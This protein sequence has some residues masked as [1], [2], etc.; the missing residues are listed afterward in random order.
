[1][2]LQED[3]LTRLARDAASSVDSGYYNVSY[4]AGRARCNLV[5]AFRKQQRSLMCEIKFASPSTGK[6]SEIKEISMVAKQMES[7]G[8]NALS[9]LT[10]KNSFNGSLE[11][12]TKAKSSVAIPVMMKDIIISK[13]QIIAADRIGADAILLIRELYDRNLSRLSLDEA[14]RFAHELDL[15]VVVESYFFE[16]FEDLMDSSSCDIA[17]INNRDL[18]TFQ[19]NFERTVKL[20]KN[21]KRKGPGAPLVMSESGYENASD[22]QNVLHALDG[23]NST[24]DAFLIGTSI[25]RA[26]NI[27]NKVREFRNALGSQ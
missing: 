3:I 11:N 23:S 24:P 22:L 10:E 18:T 21:M 16:G 13:E 12:L 25:M 14:V 20:L 8:A 15:A 1:L 4:N 7:G 9:V 2:R 26:N 5:E 19:V 6:I 17:G 27:E